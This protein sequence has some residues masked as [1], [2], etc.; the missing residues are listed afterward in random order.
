MA[1]FPPTIRLLRC[2]PRLLRIS[3]VLGDSPQSVVSKFMLIVGIV[4]YKMCYLR[5]G[6]LFLSASKS[7]HFLN[8]T[9]KTFETLKN[10]WQSQRYLL[11]HLD[12]LLRLH[13]VKN[14]F[15][16]KR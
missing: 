8:F 10:R 2:N 1:G 12:W 15:G 13:P 7:V 6:N 3:I 16:H 14:S 9:I 4:R 11:V 5:E